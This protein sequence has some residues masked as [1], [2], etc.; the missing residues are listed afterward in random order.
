MAL[1][2]AEILID[3]GDNGFERFQGP[4]WAAIFN[5]GYNNDCELALQLI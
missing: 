3:D 1:Q 2:L 5:F 4:D